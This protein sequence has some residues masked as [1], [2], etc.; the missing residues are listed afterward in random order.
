M[1]IHTGFG[2]VPYFLLRSGPWFPTPRPLLSLHE[3]LPGLFVIA[4]SGRLPERHLQH[5]VDYL[6]GKQQHGELSLRS[7]RR[8]CDYR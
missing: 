8:F 6:G 4:D 3:S 2:H 5:D 1:I 7:G